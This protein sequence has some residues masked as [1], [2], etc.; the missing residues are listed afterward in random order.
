MFC[1]VSKLELRLAQLALDPKNSPSWDVPE[2]EKRPSTKMPLFVKSLPVYKSSH[3]TEVIMSLQ[4]ISF[5]L[6]FCFILNRILRNDILT[7]GSI[8]MAGA[9]WL[10]LH[11]SD[12]ENG[13]IHALPWSALPEFSVDRHSRRD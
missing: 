13:S 11:G 2:Q 10:F 12:T 7:C 9:V 8:E 5:A 4:L 1:F 6:F 3:P